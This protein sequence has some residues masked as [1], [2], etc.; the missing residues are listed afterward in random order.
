MLLPLILVAATWAQ[1]APV[2]AS[3]E[4]GELVAAVPAAPLPGVRAD[5]DRG[6]EP[7]GDQAATFAAGLPD[8]A[9]AFL[10][11]SILGFGAGHFYAGNTNR[12][13]AFLGVEGASVL[14]YGAMYFVAVHG[15]LDTNLPAQVGDGALGIFIASRIVDMYMAPI[16]AHQCA[17]DG[18]QVGGR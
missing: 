2:P 18:H 3:S 16:T 5:T 11:S 6:T 7:P 15:N 14:L 13:L 12:G 4:A 8:P 10:Q 9:T 1:T 17:R